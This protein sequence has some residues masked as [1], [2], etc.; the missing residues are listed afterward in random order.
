MIS[1]TQLIQR[2][3]MKYRISTDLVPAVRKAIRPFCR[4]DT[5]GVD[6]VYRICSLYLDGPDRRLYRE[7]KQRVAHRF[8]LRIRRYQ[9]GPYFLEV[10]GRSMDTVR[11]TRCAIEAEHWPH[12]LHNPA[13]IGA[14]HAAEHDPH[15]YQ[16]FVNSCLV[17][18]AEPS[19]LVRY[20]REAWVSLNDDYGRVT[21]DS[22]LVAAGPMGWTIPIDD[23]VDW[24][25]TDAPRRFGFGQSGV[26]LEL[27][28]TTQL[29]YWMTDLVNRFDLRRCGFSKY[30]NAVEVTQM[31]MNSPWST[32]LGGR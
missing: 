11:K 31:G 22:K 19:A 6:G 10:K 23:E 3:E 5:A 18:L 1:S 8:K 7:T 16:N 14:I 28:C 24:Y 26:V 2:Y 13:S 17:T 29:P 15:A 21:F 12:V 30:A 27:K 32:T 4:P 20:E 25:P 9:T